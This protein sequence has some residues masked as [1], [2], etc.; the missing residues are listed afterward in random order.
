MNFQ[1]TE[2]RQLHGLFN[3]IMLSFA[4][5]VIPIDLVLYQLNSLFLLLVPWH[6]K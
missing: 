2:L 5:S 3:Q 6:S 1:V 4:F